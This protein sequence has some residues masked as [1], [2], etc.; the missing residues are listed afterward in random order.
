L[1]KEGNLYGTGVYGGA[2]GNGVVFEVTPNGTE[3]VLYSFTGGNDGS[4]PYSSLVRDKAGNL[5]GTASAGGADGAG[6][7]FELAPSGG[8]ADGNGVVFKLAPDGTETVLHG[9]MGGS[10]GGCSTSNLIKDP[11]QPGGYFYGTASLGGG[12]DDYGV[13]FKVKK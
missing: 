4:D 13:V 9:F 6:V 2:D 10:D 11:S 3:S 7:V 5:Y 12:A 1:D 8:G